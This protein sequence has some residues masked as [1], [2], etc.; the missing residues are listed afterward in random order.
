MIQMIING[1]ADLGRSHWTTTVHWACLSCGQI[2]VFVIWN[3]RQ[4]VGSN[5]YY[6]NKLRL[7]IILLVCPSVALSVWI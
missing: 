7:G 4:M 6:T 3:C 2:P 1:R 5:I